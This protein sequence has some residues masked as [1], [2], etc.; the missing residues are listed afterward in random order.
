MTLRF[1]LVLSLCVVL[2][3]AAR[4]ASSQIPPIVLDRLANAEKSLNA[5]SA[6]QVPNQ[7]YSLTDRAACDAFQRGAKTTLS[8]LMDARTA[9]ASWYNQACADKPNTTTC[10]YAAQLQKQVEKELYEAYLQQAQPMRDS[11]VEMARQILSTLG[12][13][14]TAQ[15]NTVMAISQTTG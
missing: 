9:L 8:A 7:C 1:G 15:Q 12:N 2:F 5:L 11:A 10:V 4:A 13:I 6:L 3:T 14:L